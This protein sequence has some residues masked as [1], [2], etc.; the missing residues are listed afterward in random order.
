M[1]LLQPRS[2]RH[3]ITY[4]EMLPFTCCLQHSTW[5]SPQQHEMAMI[6]H[7]HTHTHITFGAPNLARC[8]CS[9]PISCTAE[10]FI[11]AGINIAPPIQL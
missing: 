2:V 1:L 10:L 3:V 6:T 8:S 11:R 7:T 4:N 5:S 9:C